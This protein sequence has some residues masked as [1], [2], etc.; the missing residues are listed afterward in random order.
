[1]S[2]KLSQ[3]LGIRTLING[4]SLI[5]IALLI[6]LAEISHLGW[7]FAAA[8]SVIG[9]A[10]SWEYCQLLKKKELFPATALSVAAVCLYIFTVFIKTQSPHIF[11]AFWPIAPEIFLGLSFFG[12][13]AY[14]VIVEKSAITNISATFFGIVYIAVPLGLLISVIYFFTYRGINDPR[15]QGSWWM[16]Y[17]IAVTKSSDIGGYFVGRRFGRRKLAIK[18]S[19]NKTL[20]GAFAGLGISILASLFICFLGKSVGKVFEEFSY[21]QALWL[22]CILAVVGQIGDLAESFL[23]R[24]AGVKD[25]NTIPGVGGILD[26]LDSLL[27]TAPVLYVFLRMIYG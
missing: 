7:I 11:T 21:L 20:E 17:L 5:L 18:L 16:I 14:F 12:S 3:D 1:M 25:S 15:M 13:F 4:L 19:P 9:G 2:R 10:A 6:F 22:G 8:V 24:D 27:F 23:K 26:M